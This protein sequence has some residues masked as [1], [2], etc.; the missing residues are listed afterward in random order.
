M[1]KILISLII[2]LFAVS[3]ERATY[4]YKRAGYTR[5]GEHITAQY[6]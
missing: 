2:T 6:A 1:K 5:N 4:H 3:G